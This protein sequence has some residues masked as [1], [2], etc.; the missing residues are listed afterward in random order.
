MM[1]TKEIT[2]TLYCD[3]QPIAFGK[4][5]E[6]EPITD[7][8]LILDDLVPTECSFTVECDYEQ[9]KK[10]IPQGMRNAAIL[11]RDG[12]LDETNGVLE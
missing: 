4:L 6:I 1:L 8:D 9:A 5:P 3:G 12:Y 7:G 10:I 11:K 2:G